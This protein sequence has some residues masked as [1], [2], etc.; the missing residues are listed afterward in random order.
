[1]DITLTD[2][3]NGSLLF[4]EGGTRRL[5]TY[6]GGVYQSPAGDHGTL[7]AGA[8]STHDLTYRNGLVYH[9][10]SNGKIDT[11]TDRYGNHLT[12]GYPDGD[13]GTVTDS[14]GQALTFSYD[15]P[16]PPHWLQ[17]VTD[18]KGGCLHLHP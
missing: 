14:S 1:M 2:A 18:P 5:Y 12:F 3:G 10:L 6:S 9:F 8:G 4:R 15:T 17:S 7:T 16:S 13:L 11:I